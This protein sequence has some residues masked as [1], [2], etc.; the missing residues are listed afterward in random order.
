MYEQQGRYDDALR[1][2]RQALDLYQAAGHSVGYA[3]A[4]NTVGWHHALLGEHQQ[5]ITLCD[6][7]VVLHRDL[8][9]TSGEGSTWDSLG[10]AHH[11]LGHHQQAIEC[12]TNALEI[13]RQ[14][15]RPLPRGAGVGPP[16]GHLRIGR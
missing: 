3:N 16:G 8:G 5:A 14:L 12:F 10:Y 7:S 2:S 4:L 11:H 1:H 13:F 15:K 9:D 6:Q